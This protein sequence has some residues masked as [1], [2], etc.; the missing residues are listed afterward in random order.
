MNRYPVFTPFRFDDGDH[1]AIVL[2]K[3]EGS[4]ILTDEAHTL[5]RFAADGDTEPVECGVP[6]RLIE[7][8]LLR[9]RLTSRNGELVREIP[10]GA[11]GE[12]LFAF[13]QAIVEV[14]AFSRVLETTEAVQAKDAN[15]GA[16]VR[17]PAQGCRPHNQD[18]GG[19]AENR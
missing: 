19:L 17:I 5:M 4:W 8:T 15:A 1:L 3:E 10:H 14:A 6:K 13:L 11:Y 16:A 7:A 18:H 12:G 9:F 2:T